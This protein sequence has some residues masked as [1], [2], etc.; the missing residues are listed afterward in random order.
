V[1]LRRPGPVGTV[2]GPPTAWPAGVDEAPSDADRLR[3]LR[4]QHLA[5]LAGPPGTPG[6]AV[7]HRGIGSRAAR[8]AEAFGVAPGERVAAP[9]GPGTP[10]V[11]AFVAWT[12]GAALA[13]DEVGADLP[14]TRV[15]DGFGCPETGHATIRAQGAESLGLPLPDVQALVLGPGLAPVPPRVTGELYLAGPGLGRGYPGDAGLTASRFV[16]NPFDPAGG[17][18]YRTGDLVRRTRTGELVHFGRT[19][20]Q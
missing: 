5:Y 2:P 11:E 13:L 17:R 12:V 20:Q 16:A 19:D 4:S 3:P 15:L 9:S 8:L 18:M 14:G 6:A 10:V 1:P 7:T